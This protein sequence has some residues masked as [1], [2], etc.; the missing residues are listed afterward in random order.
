MKNKKITNNCQ[1]GICGILLSCIFVGSNLSG[2]ARA[3]EAAKG[4]VAATNEKVDDEEARLRKQASLD[5]AKLAARA[6]AIKARRQ[7]EVA[8]E[9]PAEMKALREQTQRALVTATTEDQRE[10]ALAEYQAM[11]EALQAKARLAETEQK[12]VKGTG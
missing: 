2:M 10:D 9:E 6:D 5:P 12:G 4:S 8:P 7:R 11:A 1:K 3:A